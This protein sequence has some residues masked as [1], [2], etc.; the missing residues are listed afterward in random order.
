MNRRNFITAASAATLLTILTGCKTKPDGEKFLGYW[1]S[2]SK[3]DPDAIHI[4]RNGDSFLFT[5]ATKDPFGG[6]YQ[7]HKLPGR[8]DGSNNTLAVG[9]KRIAYDENTDLIVSGQM[10]AHRATETEYL[11]IAQQGNTTP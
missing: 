6:G 4:T 1:K 8:L 7:I 3:Y 2:D 9:D 11:A 5:V 10:K